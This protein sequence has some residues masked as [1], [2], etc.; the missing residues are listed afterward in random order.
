MAISR[1]L[2][3]II[4]YRPEPTVIFLS[5][6]YI[7]CLFPQGLVSSG[8]FYGEDAIELMARIFLLGLTLANKWLDDFVT[9]NS[10]WYV[11]SNLG[12]ENN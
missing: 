8:A 3:I 2:V 7:S 9:K 6:W 4:H 12:V 5:L 1:L 10:T 11:I